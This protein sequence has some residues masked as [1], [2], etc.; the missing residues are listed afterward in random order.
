M[1]RH[2]VW[3]A[4]TLRVIGQAL[5]VSGERDGARVHWER[6]H[7]MF[8]EMGMPEGDEVRELLGQVR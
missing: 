5:W 4:R 3:E 2:R 8:A 6:A 1:L 7:A